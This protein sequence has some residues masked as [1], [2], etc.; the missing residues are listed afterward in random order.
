VVIG[1]ALSFLNLEIV[2]DGGDDRG[3]FRQTKD[4]CA[5]AEDTRAD[6]LVGAIDPG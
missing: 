6:V 1:D 4:I 5:Q 3:L 2:V